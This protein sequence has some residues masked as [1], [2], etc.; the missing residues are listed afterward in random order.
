LRLTVMVAVVIVLII[1]VS[2]IQWIGDRLVARLDRRTKPMLT[3]VRNGTGHNR[4]AFV[5]CVDKP[6][7]DYGSNLEPCVALNVSRIVRAWPA[8][9]E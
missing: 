1:I 9:Q 6:I 5:S 8:A 7:R 2:G 3:K 4:H